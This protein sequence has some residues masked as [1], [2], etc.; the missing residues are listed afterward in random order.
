VRT[1]VREPEKAALLAI[2]LAGLVLLGLALVVLHMSPVILMG[3]IIGGAAIMLLILYPIVGVHAFL[4]LLFIENAIGA[5]GNLTGMKI[6][7]GVILFG[8]L[9]SMAHEHRTGLRFDA[10]VVLLSLFLGWCGVSMTHAL[11]AEIAQVRLLTFVQVGIASLMFC[12]V[13]DRPSRLRSILW[14]FVIW[15]AISTVIAVIEY[16][17]GM[18]VTASGLVLNRNQLATY[19]NIATVFAYFLYLSSARGWERLLLALSLPLFFFG[20]A[21]TLSRSGLIVMGI[22]LLIVM[23]RAARE[24]GYAILGMTLALF[25]LVAAVLPVSFWMRAYSVVPAV[26]RQEETFGMRVWQWKVGL[27]MIEAHPVVGVGPGNFTT[28][29]PRYTQGQMRRRTLGAHNSYI[30]VAAEM[31]L[32]ALLLFLGLHWAALR[33]GHRMVVVSRRWN[34]S[35][36]RL[37]SEAVMLGIFVSMVGSLSGSGETGKCL[38]ILFGL[39]LSLAR[40]AEQIEATPPAP[41]IA[42]AAA[43]AG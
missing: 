7:G 17:M 26:E 13:V 33:G 43:Q 8:W 5:E 25:V 28:A 41:V 6:L 11:N 15:A 2:G 20:L 22:A 18:T 29:Y 31:G 9:L 14:G 39:G 4:M 24:R 34:Q 35:E 38:W 32:P 1:L 19:I 37:L 40:M 36:Y 21:L 16:Y 42:S 10:F 30:S 27:R 23:Y 12:S 3:V